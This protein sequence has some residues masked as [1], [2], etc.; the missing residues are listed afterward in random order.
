VVAAHVKK[1]WEGGVGVRPERFGLPAG[2]AMRSKKVEHSGDIYT[3]K[4]LTYE[5]MFGTISLW[6]LGWGELYLELISPRG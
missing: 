4:G 2:R 5:Q 1:D 6:K 3:P